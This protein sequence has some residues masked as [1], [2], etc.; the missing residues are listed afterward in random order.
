MATL[1]KLRFTNEE[2]GVQSDELI[3]SRSPSQ[4]HGPDILSLLPILFWQQQLARW[5]ATVKQSVVLRDPCPAVNSNFKSE[6]PS[7]S[8]V[9]QIQCDT[10]WFVADFWNNITIYECRTPPPV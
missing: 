2:T 7:I 3:G 1:K 5:E 9:H 8:F 10:I 6:I 4:D